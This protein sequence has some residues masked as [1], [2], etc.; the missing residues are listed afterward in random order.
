MKT[1]GRNPGYLRAVRGLPCLVAGHSKEERGDKGDWSHAG[2]IEAH[3]A[4]KNPGIGMKAPDIT[5]VPLC[6]KH[7]RMITGVV[8]G[9]G[10]FQW[11]GEGGR[12]EMQNNWIKATQAEL[13]AVLTGNATSDVA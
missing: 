5:A 8:G 9:Y 4:G 6:Q 7:H 1:R 12:R 10:I 11:L 3:H 2:P 13:V